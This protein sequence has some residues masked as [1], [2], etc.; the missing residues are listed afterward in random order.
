MTT[1]RYPEEKSDGYFFDK[2]LFKCFRQ[3][4]YPKISGEAF[5]Y[6]PGFGFTNIVL[7]KISSN[8]NIAD[9]RSHGIT[10]PRRRLDAYEAAPGT[11]GKNTVVL[12]LSG[13]DG[14]FTNI[15]GIADFFGRYTNYPICLVICTGEDTF[16]YYKMSKVLQTISNIKA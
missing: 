1:R 2:K 11:A 14:F 9:D 7:N 4:V 16:A 15:N 3:T 10:L 5:A 12:I 13:D 6:Q 8:T